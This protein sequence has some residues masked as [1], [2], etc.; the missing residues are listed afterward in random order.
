MSINYYVRESN[1]RGNKGGCTAR[2]FSNIKVDYDEL[3]D[4][5]IERGLTVNRGDIIRADFKN[6]KI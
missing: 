3:I 1:F 4:K 6:R 2:V 5:M